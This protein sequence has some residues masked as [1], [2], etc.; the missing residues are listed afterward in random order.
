MASD[1]TL[2][3]LSQ[4]SQPRLRRIK[5]EQEFHRNLYINESTWTKIKRGKLSLGYLILLEDSEHDYIFSDFIQ[6]LSMKTMKNVIGSEK[7]I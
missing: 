3:S 6:K 4:Q 7:L 2:S 5:R 1:N